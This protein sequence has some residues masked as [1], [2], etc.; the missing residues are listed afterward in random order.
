M[1]VKPRTYFSF[2]YVTV[3]IRKEF[4]ACKWCMSGASNGIRN[5]IRKGKV[6][7]MF[8]TFMIYGQ[9]RGSVMPELR[10]MAFQTRTPTSELSQQTSPERIS[11]FNLRFELHLDSG[12]YH[13]VP[14]A[15]EKH[16]ERYRF[17][18][19]Q[20]L[21]LIKD[22]LSAIQDQI[23]DTISYLC[24][25]ERVVGY[26]EMALGLPDPEVSAHH[27]ILKEQ[28]KKSR[29]ECKEYM[30]AFKRY[31]RDVARRGAILSREK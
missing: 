23:H 28:L 14:Q 24:D 1:K 11:S 17:L 3:H 6:A 8:P 27:H 16:V 20:E 26:V 4:H 10:A 7:T 2:C 5:E 12:C 29:A 19:T 15:L 25:A 30:R 9:S 18:N 31:N 21:D 22:H 13:L